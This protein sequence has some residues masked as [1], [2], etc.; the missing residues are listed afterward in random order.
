[1]NRFL[2]GVVRAAAESFALPEPVL[3]VGSYQVAGQEEIADLRGLFS[4]KD[5][6]GID[7]REGPGVD[8]VADVENLPYEIAQLHKRSKFHRFAKV[9]GGSGAE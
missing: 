5:Y 6:L 8:E 2:H 7:L 1:M 4:G 3:E 9:V